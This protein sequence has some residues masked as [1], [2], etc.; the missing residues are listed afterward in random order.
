MANISEDMS[1]LEQEDQ[2]LVTKLGE[3]NEQIGSYGEAK[4]S[5]QEIKQGLDLLIENYKLKDLI[6]DEKNQKI[7]DL[8][9]VIINN[10]AIHEKDPSLINLNDGDTIAFLLPVS[11][12]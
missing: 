11:G 2:E 8:I 10:Q 7:R 5:L 6:W 3:L 12:G 9:T 4:D 1:K